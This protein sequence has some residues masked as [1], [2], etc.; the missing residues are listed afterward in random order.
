[1]TVIN[2]AAIKGLVEATPSE[3]ERLEQG[4]ARERAWYEGTPSFGNIRDIGNAF[5][6]GEL[7]RV[8]STEDIRLIARLEQKVEGFWPYLTPRAAG[9]LGELGNRWRVMLWQDYGVQTEND[10]LAATSMVRTARYQ[11]KLI[12]AGKLASPDSNHCRGESVDLDN[13]GY[14]SRDP[15]TGLVYSVSHP[16]RE[17][18]KQKIREELQAMNP[19]NHEPVYGGIYDPRITEAAQRVAELMYDEGKINLVKEFE[20][21]PNACMHMTVSP[22]YELAA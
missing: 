19:M 12:E 22:D 11:K 15:S 1:M 10:M 3:F 20:D 13:T 18:G 9:M 2:T 14:Y 21:T 4:M 6:L 7:V 8:H 17:N 5:H 16:G